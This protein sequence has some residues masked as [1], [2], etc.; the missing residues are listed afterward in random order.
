MLFVTML[1]FGL[2]LE[3]GRCNHVLPL[4]GAF[5]GQ[6]V[7]RG[8]CCNDKMPFYLAVAHP[9]A[10]AGARRALKRARSD[11]AAAELHKDQRRT[12]P[13]RR[14]QSD[15]VALNDALWRGRE[16]PSDAELAWLQKRERML[17]DG[18]TRVSAG[19]WCTWVGGWLAGWDVGC[20]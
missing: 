11:A 6:Q 20:G 16:K 14:Y 18:K 4:L 9:G 8:L 1:F 17:L 13:W 2:E 5:I 12:N 3:D 15:D 19:L 10:D 7:M